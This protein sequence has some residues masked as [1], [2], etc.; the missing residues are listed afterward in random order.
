MIG[1]KF[2]FYGSRGTGVPATI[3]GVK[4]DPEGN[5]KIQIK[6][7]TGM[8][9]ELDPTD[10]QLQVTASHGSKQLTPAQANKY[11]KEL[12]GEQEVTVE[13]ETV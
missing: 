5:K 3:A 2:T 6:F 8:T 1:T 7:G 11:L 13:E 10:V 12:L 9:I 4:Q